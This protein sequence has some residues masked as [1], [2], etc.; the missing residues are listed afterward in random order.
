MPHCTKNGRIFHH[1]NLA[2]H[3]KPRGAGLK[4]N[5]FSRTH[6]ANLQAFIKLFSGTDISLA[7][8]E[9]R[10]LQDAPLEVAKALPPLPKKKGRP[11]GSNFGRVGQKKKDALKANLQGK[12]KKEES[13]A[14]GHAALEEEEDDE[15]EE[16]ES[17]S[18][19]EDDELDAA[20][21]AAA[22]AAGVPRDKYCAACDGK[23]RAH[24][25]KLTTG[26]RVRK[27]RSG[28]P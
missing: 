4:V 18:G 17:E 3:G 1:K 21:A 28:R 5:V 10:I 19:S 2:T 13:P 15:E 9:E 23:H 27:K 6:E 7:D 22:D 12:G 26:Q 24:T 20:D 8:A 25:C 16:S 14:N 11:R